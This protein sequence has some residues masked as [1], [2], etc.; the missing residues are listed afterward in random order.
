M[1]ACVGGRRANV[2]DRVCVR[3]FATMHEGAYGRV[4]PCGVR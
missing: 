4:H 3:V 1:C 2:G